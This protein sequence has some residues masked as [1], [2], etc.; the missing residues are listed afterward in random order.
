MGGGGGG[1]LGGGEGA[2]EIWVREVGRWATESLLEL[3]I[4]QLE[5]GNLS[6]PTISHC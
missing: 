4:I 6:H 5:L 3:Q 2:G 1:W